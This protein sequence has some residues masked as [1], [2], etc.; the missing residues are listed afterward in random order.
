MSS[1]LEIARQELRDRI[2]LRIAD[3][4]RKYELEKLMSR[5]QYDLQ[6]ATDPSHKQ[7]LNDEIAAIQR[8]LARP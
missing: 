2:E 5:H 3:R 8:E 7:T 6:R 1:A 4:H